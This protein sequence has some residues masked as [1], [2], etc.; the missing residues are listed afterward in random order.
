MFRALLP[1]AAALALLPAAASATSIGRAPPHD[2]RL[3]CEA[4]KRVID[5][6]NAG[7]LKAPDSVVPPFYYADAFGAVEPEEEQAFLHS[8]RHSQ[9]KP[10]EKPMR[11]YH[12]YR[13]HEDEHRPIYLVVIER[14]TWQE[15]RLETNDMLMTE[16]VH[17]PAYR[18][19]M[20]FWLATFGSNNLWYFRE[21]GEF[22]ELMDDKR[23]LK[24]CSQY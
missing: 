20:S 13:V 6:F 4:I 9:G 2:P 21:A 19:D 17:D 12:V 10:D 14:Q 22:Y 16:E 11:L 18:M 8:L 15:T 7:R 5:N 3:G 24:G 23:E 1:L